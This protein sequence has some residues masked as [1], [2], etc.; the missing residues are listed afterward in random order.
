MPV[1]NLFSK[2][3][4]K[5]EER[6]KQRSFTE[7]WVGSNYSWEGVNS[8]K[9]LTLLTDELNDYDS[10][11]SANRTHTGTGGP[12]G[13]T[14]LVDLRHVTFIPH[15]LEVGVGALTDRLGKLLHPLGTLRVG[16]DF[17]GLHNGEQTRHHCT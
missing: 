10:T 5:L 1:I 16:H 13:E 4:S 15:L 2:Y 11:A 12:G 9:T 7:A 3:E 8:I 17:F 14:V 6:F